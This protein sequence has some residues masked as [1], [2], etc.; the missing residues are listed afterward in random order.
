MS[1]FD[2]FQQ[3]FG[4]RPDATPQ[5]ASLIQPPSGVVNA[6]HPIDGNAPEASAELTPPPS[7]GAGNPG[8]LAQL[9]SA[10][11]AKAAADPSPS[12]GIGGGGLGDALAAG[13]DA[14]VGRSPLGA[15]GAGFA[16]GLQASSAYDS[17][18]S[19]KAR[20][21]GKDQ[22]EAFKTLFGIQHQQ[23]TDAETKRHNTA[24]ETNAATNTSNLGTYYQ[25]LIDNKG[26]D[27]DPAVDKPISNS[28]AQ[29]N[30]QKAANYYPGTPAWESMSDDDKEATRARYKQLYKENFHHDAPDDLAPYSGPPID[31]TMGDPP[32]TAGNPSQHPAVPTVTTDAPP[33]RKPVRNIPIAPAPAPP[34]ADPAAAAPPTAANPA[35]APPS[36]GPATPRS[37]AEFDLLPSGA[38]FIDP[39][40][41]LRIKP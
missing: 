26:K 21:A 30:T 15:F 41:Q 33:P 12:T 1:V 3:L 31:L 6:T 13:A 16:K 38:P 35:A 28:N 11:R 14:G 37:K 27:K 2:S 29:I 20:Q 10:L 36:G 4:V 19:D 8:V 17:K 40:G 34:V 39:Q 9:P 22:I 18:Q 25:G 32:G 23:D 24:T 7:P 5:V